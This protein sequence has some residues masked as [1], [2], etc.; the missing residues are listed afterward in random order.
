MMSIIS[1][2]VPVYNVKKYL[3]KCIDSICRQTYNALEIILVDDGSTDGSG[4]LCD[5]YAQK[6]DRICVIHKPN[7]GQAEAR[8]MALDIA[9]GEY[10]TFVDSDDYVAA[11]YI[12]VLYQLLKEYDADISMVGFKNVFEGDL[13]VENTYEETVRVVFS[14]KEA[15]RDQLHMRHIT[16][17][18]WG[19]LYKANIFAKLRFPVGEIYEDLAVT[20]PILFSAERFVYDSRQ[21]YCYLIREGSTMQRPFDVRQYVEVRW[22][23]EAM[24]LVESKY[25]ELEVEI[26]GRKVWSYFKTLY[27]ILC[28]NNRKQYIEIQNEMIK[29][30]KQGSVGLLASNCIDRNLKIKLL[31]LYFTKYGFFFV[32]KVSDTI[33]QIKAGHR[34]V[35]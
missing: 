3:A 33:K 23:E 28:S 4:D 34:F 20:Y 22:I 6:D 12:E 14:Q 7:G 30:I 9:T 25:P 15:I 8:N 13:K 29:K 32:Q 31:S 1:V 24:R 27:R 26:R 11:D 21:L 18:V 35:V 17:A 16:A 5:Q 19:R 2:I 10:I